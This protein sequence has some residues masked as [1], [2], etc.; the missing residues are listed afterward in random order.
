MTTTLDQSPRRRIQLSLL[1]RVS[2]VPWP[3]FILVI[4][5]SSIGVAMQYSAGGLAWEPFAGVHV[6]RLGI[7]FGLAVIAGLI[8]IRVWYRLSYIVF[9]VTFLMLVAVPLIGEE[10]NN[11][12]RWINLRVMTLQPSELVQIGLIMALARYF[13]TA[14]W[15]E[16][17]NPL[18]LIFPI[19]IAA[20]PT[21]LIMEQPDLGTALKLLA[22]LGMILFLAGLRWWL[23][24][25]GVGAVIGASSWTCQWLVREFHTP[26]LPEGES[27]TSCA[28]IKK[29]WSTVTWRLKLPTSVRAPSSLKPISRMLLPLATASI[30]LTC[31]SP[32]PGNTLP[33]LLLMATRLTSSSM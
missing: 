14:S 20:L 27:A 5:L 26:I 18:D 10:F 28:P 22:C 29:S 15:E 25:G 30:M 3:L 11:A 21:Y 7:F 17:G 1:D 13:N 24:M 33:I 12:K 16:L 23:V 9:F 8:D 31:S 2:S 19:A 32:A 4:I 6:L